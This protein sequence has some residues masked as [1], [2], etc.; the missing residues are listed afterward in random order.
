MR[1]LVSLTD[2]MA[3]GEI[4]NGDEEGNGWIYDAIVSEAGLQ[5]RVIRLGGLS[6][7]PSK[8]ANFV[9]IGS[10]ECDAADATKIVAYGVTA[11][12]EFSKIPLKNLRL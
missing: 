3:E 2:C 4:V 11:S 5:V 12:F 1:R 10:F 9:K 6:S 8:K 7:P